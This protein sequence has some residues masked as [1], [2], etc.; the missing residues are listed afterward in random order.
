MYSSQPFLTPLFIT[1]VL[2]CCEV[3][4][5]SSSHRARVLRYRTRLTSETRTPR[6]NREPLVWTAPLLTSHIILTAALLAAT[7]T[8]LLASALT[9]GLLASL[10]TLLTTLSALLAALSTLL[11]LLLIT[12]VCHCFDPPN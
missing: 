10:S 2:V 8:T 7:L 9:A 1:N 4:R 6:N 5:L 3:L 12:I 11:T